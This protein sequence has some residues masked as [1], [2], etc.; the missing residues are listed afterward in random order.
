MDRKPTT[1]DVIQLSAPRGTA[2]IQSNEACEA[3]TDSFLDSV[4]GE[5]A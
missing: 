3:V 4:K 5:S 2:G 1:Y